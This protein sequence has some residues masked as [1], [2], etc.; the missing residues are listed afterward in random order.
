LHTYVHTCIYSKQYRYDAIIYKK[1]R[2]SW[3]P[4]SLVN[5]EIRRSTFHTTFHIINLYL[6]FTYARCICMCIQCMTESLQISVL[7][8]NNWFTRAYIFHIVVHFECH[9]TGERS[10]RRGTSC[11]SR[12]TY[13]SV[14][15]LPTFPRALSVISRVRAR[16]N[17]NWTERESVRPLTVG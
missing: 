3:Y 14:I 2:I 17:H 13:S 11:R 10:S 15:V 6:S 12:I 4:E 5:S 1:V 8:T 16:E 7:S 9:V